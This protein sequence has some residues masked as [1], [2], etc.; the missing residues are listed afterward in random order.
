[1]GYKPASH[2]SHVVRM[3]ENLWM[4]PTAYFQPAAH[5]SHV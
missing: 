3:V 5:S 2:L 1:M 4:N